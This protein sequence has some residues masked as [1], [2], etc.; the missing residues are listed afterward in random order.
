MGWAR[1]AAEHVIYCRAGDLIDLTSSSGAVAY[2]LGPAATIGSTTPGQPE[3]ADDLGRTLRAFFG[4]S[5]PRQAQAC[6]DPTVPFDS[7]F[8]IQVDDAEEVDFFRDHYF[9]SQPHD[10]ESWRRI[11]CE[12][13]TGAGLHAE[14]LIRDA[15]DESLVLAFELPD[16]R[17]LL[18]T[19]NSD[20]GHWES[21][22]RTPDG[23]PRGW[24]VGNRRI[25]VPELLSRTILYKVGNHGSPATHQWEVG[26][27]TLTRVGLT[28]MITADAYV[29]RA[30][31]WKIP[32]DPLM[33]RLQQITEGRTI[34]ADQPIPSEPST[35]DPDFAQRVSN[36]ARTIPVVVDEAGRTKDR[37][38][39]VE[40]VL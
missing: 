19:G 30:K 1:T 12:G 40:Y 16:H 37:S 27:E 20:V 39:Y 22:Q 23:R 24:K 5:G 36:S 14:R 8:Q 21:W 17:V 11:D 26:L 25:T 9:G 28:A 34:Q 2:V 10:R 35:R 32:F 13:I 3:P 7:K 33:L 4:A 29:S 15:N 18:F 31:G 38:L 6:P